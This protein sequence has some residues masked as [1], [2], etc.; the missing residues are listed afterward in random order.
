MRRLI[1]VALI[2]FLGI[3]KLLT[4][5]RANFVAEVLK[6][7][8]GEPG[9]KFFFHLLAMEEFLVLLYQADAASGIIPSHVAYGRLGPNILPRTLIISRMRPPG[10]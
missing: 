7:L 10:L 4:K 6:L 2:F 9:Q 5:S 3:E 1:T 8:L